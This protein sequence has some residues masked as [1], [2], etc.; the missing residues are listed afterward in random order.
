MALHSK[1]RCEVYPRTK[2]VKR[3]PVPDDK[4]PWD[5]EF[6]EYAP[7]DYTAPGVEKGPVWAD[8]DFRD[9]AD[10]KAKG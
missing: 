10:S 6:P 7:V 5:T 3:F 9:S 8:V 2:E 1:A 4:V